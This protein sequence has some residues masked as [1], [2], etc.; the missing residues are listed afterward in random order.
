MLTIA[1]GTYQEHCKDPQYAQLFGSGGRAAAALAKATEVILFTY[2]PALFARE[3]RLL[4]ASFGFAVK[5]TESSD[6]ISFRYLHPLSRPKVSSYH[7]SPDQSRV[8]IEGGNILSFGMIEGNARVSGNRVVY[9]PQS[10][11]NPLRFHDNGSSAEHLAIVGNEREVLQLLGAEAVQDITAASLEVLQ[12]EVLVVKRGPSGAIVIYRDGIASVAPRATSR[13]WP[14]GSGDI[15]SAVFAY[16]WAELGEHP[17]LA[18]QSASL[19]TSLYAS[20]SVLPIPSLNT[21]DIE[22]PSL[23]QLSEIQVPESRSIYLAAPFFTMAE[24]W[25]VNECKSS[26]EGLGMRVFSPFHEIGPGPAFQV[27]PADIS[28]LRDC[29]GLFGVLDGMDPGSVFE[30]GYAHALG[31]PISILVQNEKEEDLKM[32]EGLGAGIYPDLSSA[33]Y[34]CAWA[35][36]KSDQEL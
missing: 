22:L 33:V 12:C 9:D 18:A 13:V 21:I 29:D 19:M 6:I 27:A 25:L 28:A 16:R 14:I 24:R 34:N 35:T 30:I 20:T 17:N 2:A 10:P 8:F 5:Q 31:L 23:T 26:L 11:G 36:M 7:P 15:F 32:M 3:L 4:G 1:G